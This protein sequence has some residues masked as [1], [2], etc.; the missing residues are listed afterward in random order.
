[1]N[2]RN[3][4]FNYQGTSYSIELKYDL[5]KYADLVVDSPKVR[6]W[7]QD[8]CPNYNNNG[9][10]PP[11]SPTAEELL[12]HKDFILLT[13]KVSTDKIPGE[14]MEKSKF[15]EGLLCTYMDGLG[16]KL[17]EV[18]A[19]DFLNP[20]HCRGCEECT[21]ENGCKNQ[22]RRVYSITGLGI[23]LGETIERLFKDK[24]QWFT[25]DSAPPYVIKIMAFLPK[26]QNRTILEALKH[27]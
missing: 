22:D 11:F 6:K 13:A 20:G 18:Y 19:V 25:V 27:V 3:V 9:G 14:P 12:L 21:I 4:E 24:L 5:F 8:G 10:C 1:M 7:C 23:L 17:K 2:Y 16:Y 26:G 15:I